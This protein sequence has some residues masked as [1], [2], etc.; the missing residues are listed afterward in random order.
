MFRPIQRHPY[1]YT[2]AKNM[3]PLLPPSVRCKRNSLRRT[4]PCLLT[5][6]GSIQFLFRLAGGKPLSHE[7]GLHD[8]MNLG[9][10]AEQT[11][12]DCR[13]PHSLGLTT[14]NKTASTAR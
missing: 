2:D 13:Y 5:A 7:E 3:L 6:Y 10:I 14:G 11:R 9:A 1:F 12:M 4:L 8:G